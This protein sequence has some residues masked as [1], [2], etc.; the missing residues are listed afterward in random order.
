VVVVGAGYAGLEA[1]LDLYEAGLSVVVLEARDRVGG[2]AWTIHLPDGTPAE[3]GGEWILN[4]YDEVERLAVRFGLEL[5]PAG[6]EFAR[7]EVA[8]RM[9]GMAEIDDL[10]ERAARALEGISPPE[11][12]RRSVGAFLTSLGGSADVAAALRARW[13][14]TC[15]A[16]L[17]DVALAVVEDLVAATASSSRRLAPG[18][19]ALA[20]AVA[21]RLP[22]VRLRRE[23]W[24]IEHGPTGALASAEGG[25]SVRAGAAVVALPLPRLRTM[26]FDP[27][28]PPEVA[29]A[30]DGIGFGPASKLVVPLENEPEPRARQSVEGPWWWWT[31]LG[32]DDRPRRC[33]TAFAGSTAA[34][35]AL[36]TREGDPGPW[37]AALRALEPDLRVS[38]S[39]TLATWAR[40]PYSGG[41]YTVIRP[42][43]VGRLPALERP[44]GR[45]V[46]AGEHTAGLEWHGTFEGA[47]RSGRRAAADVIE[48][49]G[50]G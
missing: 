24:R 34:Q 8:D 32:E 47:A 38:G 48:M 14:G 50:A 10:L 6:V 21:S 39:P 25:E 17:A 29:A 7:R 5:Y 22:D 45:V 33:L 41:A 36:R 28:A 26:S 35:E 12:N 4:G 43:G 3:L 44:F 19:S 20:E 27:P 1:A 23:V 42:G 13:Q 18:A 40:D 31:A 9:V 46:L 2:R 11:R 15:V 30:L 49:L 16:D 37:M